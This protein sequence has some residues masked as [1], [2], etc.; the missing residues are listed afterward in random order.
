MRGGDRPAD[1]AILSQLPKSLTASVNLTL[2]GPHLKQ[3]TPLH[4]TNT[5]NAQGLSP[6]DANLS[7]LQIYSAYG[8]K[9]RV[10]LGPFEESRTKQSFKDDT[11]INNIM[12][13][14]RSTGLVD[15]VN[16][17]SPQYGDVTGIDFFSSMQT[18][19]KGREMF[20]ELPA[21]IRNRFN[22][23]P[24]LFLD[25]VDDPQNEA[26]MVRLGL[27]VKPAPEPEKGGT[28][29][30]AGPGASISDVP[31]TADRSENRQPAAKG[32]GKDS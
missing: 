1:L 27:L 18:V 26:E 10:Q 12:A 19:A 14:F 29:P 15:Y 7:L 2:Y 6:M 28:T 20:D 9:L 17:F 5:L 4:K 23:N 24:E 16:K 30:P 3:K 21:N 8:P 22:N 32:A 25:F 13:R 11:N 31:G